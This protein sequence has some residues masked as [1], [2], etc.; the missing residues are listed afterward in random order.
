MKPGTEVQFIERENQIILQPVTKEFI[1][2][3]WGAYKEGPSLTKDLLRERAAD[4]K[5][6]ETKVEKR[7]P[8]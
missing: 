1:R 4:R 2:T 6:E 8:R 3:L 5:R 7:R